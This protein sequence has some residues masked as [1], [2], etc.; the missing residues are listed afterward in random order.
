MIT[1]KP[2]GLEALEGDDDGCELDDAYAAIGFSQET[3]THAQ[4]VV[5]VQDVLERSRGRELPGNFNPLIISELFWDQ[6]QYWQELGSTHVD[7]VASYCARFVKELVKDL[8]PEDVFNKIMTHK[9][10]AGLQARNQMAHAKLEEILEDKNDHPITYNHYYTSTMQKMRA[11]KQA[12]MTKRM[13]EDSKI[14]IYDNDKCENRTLLDP[15]AL[16]AKM[17]SASIEQDMIKFSAEDALICQMAF[18]K[19]RSGTVRIFRLEN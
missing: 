3:Q 19:V 4:A 14:T 18:Y 9:V 8:T 7:R 12:R 6:S 2:E 1:E 17:A 15:D 13:A 10:E 16:A 11:D 5:W